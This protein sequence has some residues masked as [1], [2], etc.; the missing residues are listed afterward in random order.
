M[1]LTGL[2]T[3]IA[4]PFK[5][6]A[7]IDFD[8]F[9]KLLDYQIENGVDG[10]V[11]CG[12]TGESATLS[13]KEKMSLF[14]HA[15]EYCANRTKIIAGTGSNNTEAAIDLTLVAK[16]HGADA[17]LLVSP[18]Y[19]KPSQD[20]LFAHFSLI[21]ESVDI[22]QILYNVPGRTGSNVLPET[23]LRIAE[24]CE[25]VVATKEASGD[26]EQVMQIVA[27]APEGFNVLSGD[28]A[29]T[30]PMIASGAKGVVSVISNYAPAEFGEAVRFALKGDFEAAR[31]AH[32]KIFELMKLN[33]VETNPAPVKAALASLGLIEEY[34][35]LPL[36]PVSERS[37]KLIDKAL[38][39]A[40][41]LKKPRR[42]TAKKK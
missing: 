25:N 21:A 5:E 27:R 28:D 42:K 6:D 33:F 17:V 13:V 20:G 19:N 37:K 11:V 1:N 39:E 7:S 9:D 4:T 32:F 30:L 2:Y 16:E 38:V 22:P 8:A 3:A 24:E 34:I 14:I 36:L 12:S 40:G 29:L 26:L 23:Q 18:Y 35:R 15:V 41:L 10:I 31:K